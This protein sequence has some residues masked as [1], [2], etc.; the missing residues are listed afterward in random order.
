M[1]VSEI[2]VK[3]FNAKD[4]ISHKSCENCKFPVA[5][6]TVQ[7]CGE[8]KDCE[9]QFWYG[10]NLFEDKVA[11]IL[12]WM[13]R[14]S[15]NYVFSRCIS[16]CGWSTRWFLVHFG[17]LH[18]SPSR[19]IS[20]QTLHTEGRINSFCTDIVGRHHNR[21]YNIGCIAGKS[22]RWLLEH[23]WT[24]SFV[25]CMDRF[26][27]T[28][29]NEGKVSRKTHVVREETNEAASNIQTLFVARNLEKYV[30]DR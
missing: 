7:L 5:N 29:Y 9:H 6:R 13:E 28:H 8:I 30:K 24:K 14:V 10:I 1:D 26:H 18:I 25:R 15:S 2:H 20:G 17:R 27:T 22:Y 16:G 11:K 19:Q 12:W 4:V 3:R 23:R 21:S